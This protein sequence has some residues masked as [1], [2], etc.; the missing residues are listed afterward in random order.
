MKILPLSTMPLSLF[1]SVE[2]HR[3]NIIF[4][5]F[6]RYLVDTLKRKGCDDMKILV[7]EDDPLLNSTL[8]YNLNAADYV[9]DSAMT[10]AAA[11]RLSEKQD[12]D[13]GG[14]FTMRLVRDLPDAASPYSLI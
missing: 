11:A 6:L 4:A 5:R 3:K 1:F 13:L 14:S 10:K 9:V 7:I 2:N 12:Y 8:C